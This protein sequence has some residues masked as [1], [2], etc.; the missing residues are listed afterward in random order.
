[1]P[2]QHPEANPKPQWEKAD[3]NALNTRIATKISELSTRE[4]HLST[5]EAFDQRVADITWVIQKS[6]EELEPKLKL[7]RFSKPHW[8]EKCS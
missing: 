6:I 3:W 7:T 1:M 5:P 4:H 8:T 2:P